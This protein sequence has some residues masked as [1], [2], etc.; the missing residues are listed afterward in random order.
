MSNKVLNEDELKKLVSL[1]DKKYQTSE[2]VQN[3]IDNAD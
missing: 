3:F 1:I 2:A